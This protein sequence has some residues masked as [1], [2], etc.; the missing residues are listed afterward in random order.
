MENQFVRSAA[1]III[2]FCRALP[3]NTKCDRTEYAFRIHNM[4][5]MVECGE[6]AYILIILIRAAIVYS[7]PS[8]KCVRAV[9]RVGKLHVL[10]IRMHYILIVNRDIIILF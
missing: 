1:G 6:Y 7:Y 8:R 9:R 5:C 10:I 3:N 2:F 4:R